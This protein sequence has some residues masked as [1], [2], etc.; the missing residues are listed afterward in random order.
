MFSCCNSCSELVIAP[1]AAADARVDQKSEDE[2]DDEEEDLRGAD[3]KRGLRRSGLVARG[4]A[5]RNGSSEHPYCDLSH[6]YRADAENLA[7]EH[8]VGLDGRKHNLEDA[9]LVF[10]SM[11]ERAVFHGHRSMMTMYMRKKRR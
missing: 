6:A 2:I 5:P 10:S 3:G 9:G 1:R 4:V 11:M 7:G 8:L